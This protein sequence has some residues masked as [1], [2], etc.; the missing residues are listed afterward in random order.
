ME[1]N[2][3]LLKKNQENKLRMAPDSI[4]EF[5][6]S[7]RNALSSYANVRERMMVACDGYK[8]GKEYLAKITVSGKTMKLF[9]ALNPSDFDQSKFRHT[10]V[11]DKKTY[12]ST[13]FMV[14]IASKLAV[15]RALLLIEELAKKYE[16]AKLD[17]YN[18]VDF[19]QLYPYIENGEFEKAT[20]KSTKKVVKEE[21]IV[22]E[23]IEVTEPVVEEV[24]ADEVTEEVASEPAAEE[25]VAEVAEHVVE[26]VV[27]PVVEEAIEESEELVFTQESFDELLIS[28]FSSN[29]KLSKRLSKAVVNVGVLDE[30]FDEEEV[31]L[32]T[33]KSKGLINRNATYV[34]L[35]GAGNVT[36]HHDVNVDAMSKSAKAKLAAH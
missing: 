27:E 3:I 34:K 25:V 10:D 19:L 12:A 8:L 36:K 20:K 2:V 26:E 31:N 13:P 21:I 28:V 11:S 33:L 1:A 24:A 17:P 29:K 18:E 7:I 9:L 22:E 5:Y 6:S 16:L 15:K 23:T 14:K 32:L 4:K 35:L 30:F